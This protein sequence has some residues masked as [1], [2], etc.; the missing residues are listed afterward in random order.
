MSGMEQNRSRCLLF[1]AGLA[2]GAVASSEHSVVDV[3][4]PFTFGGPK[5]TAGWIVTLT[6]WV[7]LPGAFSIGC[8]V[9]CVWPSLA[10]AKGGE[11]DSLTSPTAKTRRGVLGERGAGGSPAVRLSVG[12]ACT[13]SKR[14]HVRMGTSGVLRGSM[15]ILPLPCPEPLRSILQWYMQPLDGVIPASV[16]NPAIALNQVFAFRPHATAG[17]IA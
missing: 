12:P 11:W 16:A 14:T 2:S 17:R 8:F 13:S 1:L 10:V 9:V 6:L 3:G 4:K 5:E 7:L 15:R